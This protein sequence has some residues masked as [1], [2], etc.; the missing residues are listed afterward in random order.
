M[1]VMQGAPPRNNQP[2]ETMMMTT[3]LAS[4]KRG[5]IANPWRCGVGS[6]RLRRFKGWQDGDG[7]QRVW[8]S[9]YAAPEL[10]VEVRVDAQLPLELA[11]GER[12]SDKRC[13][14]TLLPELWQRWPEAWW[15]KTHGY[16]PPVPAF[17]RRELLV[18][19]AAEDDEDEAAALWRVIERDG[20]TWMP[21][22]G[23]VAAVPRNN[24][25]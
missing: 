3:E 22:R 6:V 10:C 23:G 7:E 19:A 9:F 24:Q 1:G 16:A 25:Q 5:W 15:G 13:F 2:I 18:E 4:Q 20:C 12:G 8:V 17:R 14:R 21:A 11:D